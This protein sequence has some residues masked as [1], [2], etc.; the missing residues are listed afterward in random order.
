MIVSEYSWKTKDGMNI[1]GREWRP[2]GSVK[3]AL[4][5]VHGLGE[6]TGRFQYVA[7]TLTNAGY[8]VVG[9]DLRGH[10]ESDGVRGHFSYDQTMNDIDQNLQITAEHFPGVPIY[11]YGHSLGGNLVTFHTLT[12]KSNIDGVIVTSP[13]LT[14]AVPVPPGKMALA[15][16]MYTCFPSFTMNNDIDLSSLS[17]DPVVIDRYV[18]DPLVHPK[19]SA[20][21]GLDMLNAGYYILDHA[22]DVSKK[23][24]L[25]QGGSDHIVNPEATAEFAQKADHQM[26]TYHEFPE[27]LHELHNEPQKSEVLG[28]IINWLN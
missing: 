3:G 16:F 22:S 10:G 15:K 27:L 18:H 12:H 26:V 11:L 7:E 28:I 14:P 21:L 4:S 19:I 17:H 25:L 9:F 6:H 1:F 23:M 24:L 13:I 5:L 8:A 20:R 2:E